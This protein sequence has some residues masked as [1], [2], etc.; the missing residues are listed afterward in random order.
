MNQS[1]SLFRSR[2]CCSEDGILPWS[3]VRKVATIG[4]AN[5]A[6]YR[7]QTHTQNNF[8][9]C[10]L[11]IFIRVIEFDVWINVSM[12]AFTHFNEFS[13]LCIFFREVCF[14]EQCLEFFNENKQIQFMTNKGSSIFFVLEFLSPSHLK[15][16]FIS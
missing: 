8:W 5:Y 12:Y 9:Y 15:K 11:L 7:A 16:N 10:I 2:S 13:F 1:I 14:L 6:H 4:F 3:S